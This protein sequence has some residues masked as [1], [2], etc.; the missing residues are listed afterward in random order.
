MGLLKESF[1]LSGLVLDSSDYQEKMVIS[2]ENKPTLIK[3]TNVQGIFEDCSS[4][5]NFC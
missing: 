1:I 4:D 2:D 5:L 3:P